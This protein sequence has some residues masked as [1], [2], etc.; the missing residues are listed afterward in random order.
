MLAR[1]V[2]RTGL[3]EASTAHATATLTG[4]H[5]RPRRF[6]PTIDHSDAPKKRRIRKR[7]ANA[8]AI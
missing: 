4:P 7:K 3:A 8:D 1:R 6:E 2:A 5:K